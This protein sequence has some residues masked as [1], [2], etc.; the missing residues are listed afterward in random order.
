MIVGNEPNLNRYWLP[1]FNDDGSD[2][3]APAYEALLAQTYDAVKA[4]DPSVTVLGG[5]V[6]PRGGDVPDGIRP[7]HSPTVFIQRPGLGVPRERPDDADH[8]RLRVPPVRG[9]LEHRAGDRHAP[10]HDDDRARRLRQARRARSATAFGRLRRCRSGTTS[11]ASSRRSRPRS[12]ALHR[13]GAGDDEA[14]DEATQ[15]AYYRQAMQLAFCQPNVRGLFLFHAFDERALTGWQSGL[16]YADDTPKT[17][18]ARSGSAIEQSRRGVVAHCDRPAAAVNAEGDAARR[19][20]LRS[21]ATSTARTSRSSTGSPAAARLASTA[22]RSAVKPSHAAVR[23]S[24]PT[25]ADTGFASRR[26]ASVNPGI[27][28]D[29]ASS[30]SRRASIHTMEGQYVA[31]TFYRV[32]PAWRRLA[33]RGAPGGE[34]RVRRGRRGVRRP[35]RPPARVHDDRRAAGD[36][37]LPLEDHRPLRGARRARRRAERHAARRLARDAVLV[38]RDDEGLAVHERAPR[39]EDHAA[40]LAVPRRL[41]VREGAALV[42]ALDGG[43]AARDG[44]AHHDRPRGVPGHQEPHDATRSG[45]TTRSS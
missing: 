6:S 11:S 43:P 14:G 45:S 20:R 23:E 28:V 13:H 18:L 5:A 15:A 30:L 7:T 19:A 16:Y 29:A 17:S 3:A 4:A 35:L 39:A 44:R 24:R 22:R 9:Q 42:R 12:R 27:A 38:S 32:D 21:P 33:G 36:G 26:S 41:S 37:L 40:G 1:Q 25:R 2:A 8:G 10:E 34:G 31:Y